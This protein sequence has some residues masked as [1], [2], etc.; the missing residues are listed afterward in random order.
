MSV[1][2]LFILGLGLSVDSFAVSVCTGLIQ[3][4]ILIL[5]YLKIGLVLGLCQ[6]IAPVIG[7]ILG[8]S[9]KS[10]LQEWDHWIALVLLVGIGV[11]MIIDGIKNKKNVPRGN[12]LKLRA[13]LIMGLATSIDAVVVG[14]GFG[15]IGVSLWK[16][17]LIIGVVTF[18]AAIL[19]VSLG[20]RFSSMTRLRLE[21]VA[22]FVLIGIGVNTLLTHLTQ[23]I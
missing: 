14:V 3:K 6:G 7:G 1:V 9:V 23:Q 5:H 2:E 12:L 21:I 8:L 11:K 19:G 4:R 22:G 13:L 16:S 20:A 17:A 10:Y 15:L 18:F